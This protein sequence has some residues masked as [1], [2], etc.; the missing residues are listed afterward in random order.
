MK[1]EEKEHRYS[2]SIDLMEAVK[3]LDYE[4]RYR[5]CYAFYDAIIKYSRRDNN[6]FCLLFDEIYE[7]IYLEMHDEENLKIHQCIKEMDNA[8]SEIDRYDT[9]TFYEL[10][11]E[12]AKFIEV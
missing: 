1:E 7:S 10:A 12:M 8:L 4:G 9:G 3:A 6:R 2:C 5:A 11:K